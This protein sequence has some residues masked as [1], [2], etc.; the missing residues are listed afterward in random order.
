MFKL[1]LRTLDIRNFLSFGDDVQH[2]ALDRYGLTR[3]MGENMCD[4]SV[5]SNGSGKTSIIDA[6]IWCLFNTTTRGAK[7]AD[8]IRAGS[9]LCSVQCTFD[10]GSNAYKV[11][12]T[13]TKGKMV[14]TLYCNDVDI[15][16][17]NVNTC[18]A[19]LGMD[20]K[21]FQTL[22]VFS[23]NTYRFSTLTARE[24]MSV[25]DSILKLSRITDAH[26]R[27][28]KKQE[29][30]RKKLVN[31]GLELTHLKRVLAEYSN[32]KFDSARLQQAR[33]SLKSTEKI[34]QAYVL[35]EKEL[36]NSI[37]VLR[38]TCVSLRVRVS[39]YEKN[40]TDRQQ[41]KCAVC[42]TVLRKKRN[43]TRLK[44]KLKVLSRRE[45]KYT[46]QLTEKQQRLSK[47]RALLLG[48]TKNMSQLREEIAAQRALRTASQET[49]KI[50]AN[51]TAKL[52]TCKL[53]QSRLLRRKKILLDFAHI[54]GPS[55]VKLFILRNKVQ[56]LNTIVSN[57]ANALSDTLHIQ[58]A[59][60]KKQKTTDDKP[61]LCVDIRH[62]DSPSYVL[63]EGELAK[64]DLV[65]SISLQM[66]AARNA[67]TINVVFFDEP[68]D[69]LDDV[70]LEKAVT[71][72][73]TLTREAPYDS[74]FVV[75]HR[76][77]LQS[78]ILSTLTVRKTVNG[79]E[80]VM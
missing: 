34:L 49:R 43:D 38:A 58:F 60:H 74:V 33:K 25:F 61:E 9:K 27:V 21:L 26:N 1:F 41:K 6:V 39:M 68:F 53:T 2:I 78:L 3:I 56:A 79:S 71:F 73:E 12:R 52:K 20:A 8:V 18:E 24:R 4:S 55:G 28:L 31:V 46:Q 22:F 59:L 72:L 69:G 19:V 50:R 80:I 45:Q 30:V 48:C 13:R 36:L 17:K 63:S 66:Y 47:L 70:G 35:E 65:T 67:T 76:T 7:G 5:V 51:C 44:A 54:Y 40:C 15:T 10:I 11:L 57:V 75:S 62:K 23:K 77:V 42:G 14:F 16:E 29:I 32:K 64:V 37:D